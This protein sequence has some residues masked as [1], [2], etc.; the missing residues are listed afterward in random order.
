MDDGFNILNMYLIL[1][2]IA[3]L[4]YKIGKERLFICGK[5]KGTH[6]STH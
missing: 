2:R 4:L 3:A 6:A 1:L 5:N